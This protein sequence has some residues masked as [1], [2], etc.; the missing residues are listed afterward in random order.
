MPGWASSTPW[1]GRV[2]ELGVGHNGWKSPKRRPPDLEASSRGAAYHVGGP[3]GT[4]ESG[5]LPPRGPAKSVWTEPGR[6]VELACE[7]SL[8]AA[9]IGGIWESRTDLIDEWRRRRTEGR[10]VDE[11]TAL[12]E[13]LARRP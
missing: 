12:G 5:S 13:R 1:G 4:Q 3:G 10:G 2:P 8:P 11:V 6:G 9:K 7:F